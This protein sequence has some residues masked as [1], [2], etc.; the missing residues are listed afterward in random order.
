MVY[1]SSTCRGYISVILSAL[2]RESSRLTEL[3]KL[4]LTDADLRF[5]VRFPIS[6]GVAS[7]MTLRSIGDLEVIGS[8]PKLLHA[9]LYYSRVNGSR[10]TCYAYRLFT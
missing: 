10:V 1:M 7:K 2:H 9:K 4:S 3:H 5:N 6:S 8:Y